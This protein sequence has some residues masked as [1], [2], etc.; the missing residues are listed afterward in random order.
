MSEG[1][2]SYNL[3][4]FF[5]VPELTVGWYREVAERRELEELMA[6]EG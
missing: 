2:I 3:L 5:S 1:P 6:G 4:V